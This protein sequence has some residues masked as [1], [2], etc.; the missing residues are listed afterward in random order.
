MHEQNTKPVPDPLCT[1]LYSVHL[2]LKYSWSYE[3]TAPVNS[4]QLHYFIRE[5]G[6]EESNIQRECLQPI[7]SIDKT[8]IQNTHCGSLCLMKLVCFLSLQIPINQCQFLLGSLLMQANI[9][10]WIKETDYIPKTPAPTALPE[11]QSNAMPYALFIGF[12]KLERIIFCTRLHVNTT[13]TYTLTDR[14]LRNSTSPQL[15]SKLKGNC[16][17]KFCNGLVTLC[18][19]TADVSALL[20]P[21]RKEK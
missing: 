4:Y 12:S 5:E 1:H 11:L 20:L 2:W 9:F 14:Y 13:H 6:K 21:A 10:H 3:T 8:E 17:L 7:Y 18:Q 15:L 19:K 16:P